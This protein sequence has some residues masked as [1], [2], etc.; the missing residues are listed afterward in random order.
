M[1]FKIATHTRF[2]SWMMFVSLTALSICLYIGYMWVAE[3]TSNVKGTITEVYSTFE[4]Y[5]CVFFCVGV[6]LLLD[7]VLVFVGFRK[8]GYA[9]KMRKVVDEEMISKKPYYEELS[10]K[11]SENLMN[12]HAHN[13]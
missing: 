5:L 4:T 7:G 6:L 2:W 10:L 12:T 9:S 11:I 13:V 1:S 8:G 3:T